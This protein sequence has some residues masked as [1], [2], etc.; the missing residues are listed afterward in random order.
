L[1][2]SCV[3]VVVVGWSSSSSTAIANSSISSI[4]FYRR[5]I[6]NQRRSRPIFFQPSYP[7]LSPIHNN[8]ALWFL[9]EIDYNATTSGGGIIISVDIIV[10]AML[11]LEIRATSGFGHRQRLKDRVESWRL[12]IYVQHKNRNKQCC[13][14]ELRNSIGSK[15]TPVR[16]LRNR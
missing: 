1:L 5:H 13:R 10:V 16:R 15:N 6:N 12:E 8:Q 9:Q 2:Q 7:S 14:S 4:I 3:A 11:I